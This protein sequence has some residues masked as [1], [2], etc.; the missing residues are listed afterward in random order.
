MFNNLLFIERF[1]F[2]R[3]LL[4]ISL[5]DLSRYC[6]IFNTFSINKSTFSLWENGKQIPTISNLQF[7]AD[8]FSVSLDWLAGRS[9]E[10]YTESTSYF[11]EPK[12]FPLTV[13]VCDTTVELPIEIPED[14]K[15]YELRKKTYSLETRA[16]INFLFYV[17]SYEWE[18]YVG[19]N[20]SEFADKDAPAI[21]IHAYKLFHYFMINQSNK[22]KIVGYQKSLENIFRTKSI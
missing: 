13:I 17:L 3:G 1:K 4:N 19:D 15:D 7:V 2:I 22:S 18:R 10:M 9:E 11:L 5:G 21:K 12:A 16:R 8:I 14:Y 20:I 6:T